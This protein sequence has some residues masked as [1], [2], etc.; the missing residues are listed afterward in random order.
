MAT[1]T[2]PWSGIEAGL[3]TNHVEE[4]LTRLK[5]SLTDFE[6]D[7]YI[8]WEDRVAAEAGRLLAGIS[9]TR[10]DRPNPYFLACA[11]VYEALMSFESFGIPIFSQA[12]YRDIVQMLGGSFNSYLQKYF[13]KTRLLISEIKRIKRMPLEADACI[14]RIVRRMQDALDE[15]MNDEIESWLNMVEADAKEFLEISSGS[16]EY[17]FSLMAASAV[18]AAH[19]TY[20][21][22]RPVKMGQLELAEITGDSDSSI[23]RCWNA[24]FKPIVQGAI[25]QRR[26]Q[27]LAV[28]RETSSTTGL[29]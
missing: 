27:V 25:Q 19:L 14:K 8:H 5:E 28:E 12:E 17:S 4:V 3:T 6:L 20:P 1:I 18:Y 15:V 26:E 24:V 9:L 11:A 2:G 23:G 7:L 21:G 13:A 10:R 29:G 22:R 16:D